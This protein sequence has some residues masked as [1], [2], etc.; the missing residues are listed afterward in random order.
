MRSDQLLVLGCGPKGLAIAAKAKVLARSGY[1]VPKVVVIEKNDVAANWSGN[2][3]YTDGRHSLGTPPE[4][5]VGFPYRSE[6]GAIINTRMFAYSYHAF[7]VEEGLYAD[8]IDR[9]HP[10]PDHRRWAAYQNWVAQKL[11][12]KPLIAEV[13]GIEIVNRKWRL[14][15]ISRKGKG[16]I[17]GIGLVVTGPGEPSPLPG[18]PPQSFKILDGKNYWLKASR[19]DGLGLDDGEENVSIGVIG[20]GETAAAIVVDLLG[21]VGKR[22]TITVMNRQ[23]AVF[24][25]GESYDE[26][27]LF[28][29]PSTWK[30]LHADDRREF[31]SRTDRGVFSVQ[32][33]RVIDHAANVRHEIMEVTDVLLEKG[34]VVVRGMYRNVANPDIDFDFLINAISF[35]PLTFVKCLRGPIAK[36]FLDRRQ[37]EYIILDDLSVKEIAPKL[38]LPMLAGLAEGPGFPNL[39]CLGRLSDRV[40]RAYARPSQ[41]SQ[42]RGR[43]RTAGRTSKGTTR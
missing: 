8:W 7:V 6:F 14:T 23:G 12:L 37:I 27:T 22:A 35:D 13:V 2:S 31:M 38:H 25:R 17:E 32:T 16:S 33:K 10:S 36:K 28:S 4:K 9:G 34:K 41:G 42:G 26:N 39:S 30:L 21:R 18:T 19:F 3:G 40:L 5:D 1:K 24:S 11:G 20:S 43:P 29:D 15:Y